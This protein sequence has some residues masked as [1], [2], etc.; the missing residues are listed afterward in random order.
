MLYI[1]ATKS[2]HEDYVFNLQFM[3]DFVYDRFVIK[4]IFLSVFF[5]FCFLLLSFSFPR[6]SYAAECTFE[7][8]PVEV[9][10]DMNQVNLTIKSRDLING[11]KYYVDIGGWKQG[12]G[13]PR[14]AVGGT[15]YEFN[16][17]S[18]IVE[19]ARYYNRRTF[20]SPS[21]PVSVI[22][23]SNNKPICSGSIP[24]KERTVIED[25]C[26]IDFLTDL[27]PSNSLVFKVNGLETNAPR[28]VRVRQ[29]G[30]DGPEAF[31]STCKTRDELMERFELSGY[32]YTGGQTYYLEITRDCDAFSHAT[33]PR[34]CSTQ[35]DI[36]ADGGSKRGGEDD[37]CNATTK[38][39]D[40]LIC[41]TDS[42]GK[43]TCEETPENLEST[44]CDI[45]CPADQECFIT[46]DGPRCLTVYRSPCTQE[47]GN[48]KCLAI[49]SGLGISIPTEPIP[50][51]KKLMSILLGLAGG[52]ALV[53]II[54]SGYRLMI[55]QGDA[56]KIKGAR[57]MLTAAIV[58]LLFIIFSLVI[59][60]FI[61]VDILQIPGFSG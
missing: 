13:S 30:K 42:T 58:G 20:A 51:L 23:I 32:S 19:G 60:Q 21:V 7:T 56:E 43:G 39:A 25:H 52:I 40:K 5:I 8:D 22:E 44:K 29:G 17:G 4:K 3:V 41:V 10:T 53:I 34:L 2:R 31:D 14:M 50:F 57:E 48:N 49:S 15:K 59:L 1:S 54:I 33:G 6:S 27:R 28:G 18:L 55:S 16:N 38:C 11:Q 24:V 35:F 12:S 26:S 47:G 37:E 61:T 9:T 45:S 36:L 46:G